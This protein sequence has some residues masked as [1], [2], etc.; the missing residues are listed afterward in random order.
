MMI[1][2]QV[3]K[4]RGGGEAKGRGRR[5]RCR[6]NPWNDLWR[7]GIYAFYPLDLMLAAPTIQS[8]KKSEICKSQFYREEDFLDFYKIT[9]EYSLINPYLLRSLPESRFQMQ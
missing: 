5:K 6:E 3:A 9:C 4:G 7:R 1:N 2:H 8:C